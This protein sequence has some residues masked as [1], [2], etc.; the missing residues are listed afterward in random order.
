MYKNKIKIIKRIK[1]F[2]KL[3]LT[4]HENPLCKDGFFHSEETLRG[5]P[6]I[7]YRSNQIYHLRIENWSCRKINIKFNDLTLGIF[8]FQIRHVTERVK[9]MSSEKME[10]LR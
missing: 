9:N 1:M 7:S 10:I 5:I 4:S 2:T 6:N 8:C 3:F